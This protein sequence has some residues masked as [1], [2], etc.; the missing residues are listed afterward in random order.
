MP[1]PAKGY[2]YLSQK[3]DFIKTQVDFGNDCLKTRVL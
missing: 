1:C 3:Q 2:V